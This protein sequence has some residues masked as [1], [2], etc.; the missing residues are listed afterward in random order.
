MKSIIITGQEIG[1]L[2]QVINYLTST[3]QLSEENFK[4]PESKIVFHKAQSIK[5]EPSY[6]I[7]TVP[8]G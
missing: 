1:I 6:N 7:T 4:T 2:L 3:G 5:D 8:G